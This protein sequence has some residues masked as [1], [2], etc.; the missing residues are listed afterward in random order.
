MRQGM[1]RQ[2]EELQE[3]LLLEVLGELQLPVLRRQV[4]LVLRL[5]GVFSPC[6]ISFRS[7]AALCIQTGLRFVMKLS[8]ADSGRGPHMLSSCIVIWTTWQDVYPRPRPHR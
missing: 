1:Y 3:M 2:Q 4:Q 5:S 6:A 7:R 8:L